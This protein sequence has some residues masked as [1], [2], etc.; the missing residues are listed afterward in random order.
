V[1]RGGHVKFFVHGMLR[2]N[3]RGRSEGQEKLYR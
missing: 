3:R 1:W 2:F